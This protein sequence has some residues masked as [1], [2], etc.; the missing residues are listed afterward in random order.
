MNIWYYCC[1]GC[2]K[3]SS[4]SILTRNWIPLK[5]TKIRGKYDMMYYTLYVIGQYTFKCFKTHV[6]ETLRPSYKFGKQIWN[7]Y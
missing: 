5:K 2:R 1:D 7:S 6:T 3:Y 4:T